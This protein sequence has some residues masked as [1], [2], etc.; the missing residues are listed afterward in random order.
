MRFLLTVTLDGEARSYQANLM[1]LCSWIKVCENKYLRCKDP[2]GSCC[3]VFYLIYIDVIV[4]EAQI[5]VIAFET[6]DI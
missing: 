2:V 1:E 5:I 6:R 3:I 4:G